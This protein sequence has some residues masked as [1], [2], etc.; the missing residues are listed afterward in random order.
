M[1]LISWY[2]FKGKFGDTLPSMPRAGSAQ[3]LRPMS[4]H[5]LACQAKHGFWPEFAFNATQV[6]HKNSDVKD[7]LVLPAKGGAQICDMC[8]VSAFDH[9]QKLNLLMACK[10]VCLKG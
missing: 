9:L 3:N 8:V 5:L 6:G 4:G 10:H 2:L 1:S 7:N